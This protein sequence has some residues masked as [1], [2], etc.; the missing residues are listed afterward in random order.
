MED[1]APVQFTEVSPQPAQ[2]KKYLGLRIA[3]GFLYGI[4]IFLAGFIV[5]AALIFLVSPR[6][7]T[8]IGGCMT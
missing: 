2:T 7:S 4:P 6:R 8:K 3:A 1:P 5:S